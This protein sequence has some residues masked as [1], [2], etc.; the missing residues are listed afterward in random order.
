VAQDASEDFVSTSN[1]KRFRGLRGPRAKLIVGAVILVIISAAIG[2]ITPRLVARY[3]KPTYVGHDASLVAKD[4]NCGQ[5]KKE[6]KHDESVYKYHDRGTCVLSGTVVTITTFDK[7]SDGD[8]FGAVMRA[9]IPVLHPT[10][11]GATYA[12]GDGWNV[13]D[14]TNLTPHVAELAVRQLGTGAVY[15]IPSAK[16][17]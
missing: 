14:A 16:R 4:M 15:V 13:A 11:V 3:N 6:F 7:V 17:S 10:W 2:W 5:Y 1:P 8:A 12:A 9:V